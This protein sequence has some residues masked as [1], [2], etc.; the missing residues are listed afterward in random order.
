LNNFHIIAWNVIGEPRRYGHTAFGQPAKDK[1]C[2]SN[3]PSEAGLVILSV[4]LGWI[5]QWMT[6]RHYL[7][8]CQLDIYTV[9]NMI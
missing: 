4:F 9:Y 7:G 8:L 2:R 5:G 3:G 6:P 1:M